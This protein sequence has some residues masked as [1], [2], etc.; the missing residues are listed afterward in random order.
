MEVM[1]SL[2]SASSFHMPFSAKW[3]Y[4]PILHGEIESRYANVA[5]PVMKRIASACGYM[6][7]T[8]FMAKHPSGRGIQ[9]NLPRS[10]EQA[11]DRHRRCQ[12]FQPIILPVPGV[13]GVRLI[14]SPSEPL[15]KPTAA[16][17]PLFVKPA[18]GDA[19]EESD[20][21]LDRITAR[22]F[23]SITIR[24]GTAAGSRSRQ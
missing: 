12:V 16:T 2:R 10:D 22:D 6:E 13:P 20:D 14:S 4:R 5:L 17:V 3:T 1:H 7:D 11:I 18:R 15:D 23:S 8:A 24:V 19:G 21:F 9:G